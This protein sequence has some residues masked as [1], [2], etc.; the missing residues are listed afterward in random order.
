MIEELYEKVIKKEDLRGT[1]IALKEEIGNDHQRRELIRIVNGDPSVFLSLLKDEDPK[2]RK[3][4]VRILGELEDESVAAE[5]MQAYRLE[6]TRFIK[7]DYIQALR[8]L[9]YSSFMDELESRF[10]ILTDI[11]IEEAQKKHAREEAKEIKRLL[12]EK[13]GIEMHTFT[14][15]KKETEIILTTNRQHRELTEVQ[16][17]AYKRALI[18]AGVK[19][20]VSDLK[21]I[22]EVRTFDELLFPLNCEHQ[23]PKDPDLIATEIKRSNL[24]NFLQKT[25]KELRPFY[26][27]L[28]V[29][30]KM[31]LE[32]R[33]HFTKKLAIAL[34]QISGGELLN[35]TT[36]YE[37]ELRLIENREG[38]F[39][40]CLK[41]YTIADHRFSYRKKN[42]ATS[43]KPFQA[44]TLMQLCRPYFIE[45]AQ[46]LDPFCGVGTMMVEREKLLPVKS[47]YGIDLFS[48]A[49]DGARE[50]TDRVQRNFYFINRN[51]FDF[52]HEYLFDEIVTNMPV[53]GRMTKD[54]LDQIYHRF[55][56]KAETMLHPGGMIF[57][58]SQ[59]PGFV[60]KQLRL[61]VNYNLCQEYCMDEKIGS[62]LFIIATKE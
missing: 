60:K 39:Y 52:K 12:V 14:G 26:F 23:L 40:P 62:Y 6:E 29:R 11:S 45:D 8:K 36:G 44:A 17:R 21:P 1:L 61:H 28:D 56:E 30:S 37:M 43:I 57:L 32:E 9:D 10:S 4:A 47:A 54:D 48:E 41:L 22:F 15:L 18:P 3:N 55:F 16:L 46:I 7:S 13:K 49:I 50:N 25:H 31:T 27:R 38:R 42:V 59:E 34:E 53:R 58:Y 35:A 20:I 33:S 2:V 5:I 19:L 24:L 51:F